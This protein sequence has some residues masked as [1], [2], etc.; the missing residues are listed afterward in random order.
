MI[1]LIAQVRTKVIVTH[2]VLPFAFAV[3]E[4]DAEAEVGGVD[5]SVLIEIEPHHRGAFDIELPPFG[6]QHVIAAVTEDTATAAEGGFPQCF[7]LHRGRLVIERVQAKSRLTWA[8]HVRTIDES[9]GQQFPAPTVVV[10]AAAVHRFR[11]Q[12]VAPFRDVSLFERAIELNRL[13]VT[14][15][16][17]RQFGDVHRLDI[18]DLRFL[19]ALRFQ[20][21]IDLL[22]SNSLSAGRQGETHGDQEQ[23][24]AG[25]KGVVEH[26]S[27]RHVAAGGGQRATMIRD[28]R[29]LAVSSADRHIRIDHS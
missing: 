28:V 13:A 25:A 10:G 2:L 22:R 20:E 23:G 19:V 14:V 1:E 5:V 21:G 7:A 15:R 27:D 16:V 12:V 26:G 9:I 4:R 8:R 17:G 6:A 11:G 29:R 18:L 3:G 24:Q